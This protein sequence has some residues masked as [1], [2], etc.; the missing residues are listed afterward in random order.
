MRMASL[1]MQKFA[2]VYITFLQNIPIFD[3]VIWVPGVTYKVRSGIF[4]KDIHWRLSSAKLVA[5]TKQ[6]CRYNKSSSNLCN[7]TPSKL[8]KALKYLGTDECSLQERQELPTKVSKWFHF[9]CGQL[10]PSN[11]GNGDPYDLFYN[12]KF[13]GNI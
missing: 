2:I 4:L 13:V 11:S 5:F 8:T 12:C 1:I 6:L 3:V 9:R 7:S 10:I